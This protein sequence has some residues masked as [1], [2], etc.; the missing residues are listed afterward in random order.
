MMISIRLHA[1]TELCMTSLIPC[2]PEQVKD[3]EDMNADGIQMIAFGP[4]HIRK[5]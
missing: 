2:G 4:G 1:T 5:I 3:K